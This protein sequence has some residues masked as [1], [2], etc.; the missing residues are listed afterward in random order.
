M[1]KNN[2]ISLPS[3]YYVYLVGVCV[4]V[5]NS[6]NG[7]LIENILR[8]NKATN[9]YELVDQTSNKLLNKYSELLKKFPHGDE[10]VDLFENLVDMRNRI[11]HSY[12]IT[13]KTQ[14]QILGTKTKIKDG[15]TQFEITQNYMEE[16]IE[17]NNSLSS[18]LYDL[19]NFLEKEN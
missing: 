16:F 10:I 4:C 17:K 18:K 15:N 8:I 12:R 2:R 1:L 19:R 7:F 11:L 3:D 14:E 5:F 13:S 9:W 6:N